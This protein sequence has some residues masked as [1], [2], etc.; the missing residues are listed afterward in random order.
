[1]TK[2]SL[3]ERA[4][5]CRRLLRLKVGCTCG[6]GRWGSKNPNQNKALVMRSPGIIRAGGCAS[7]ET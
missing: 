5:D 1:M 2:Y 3:G 4:A 6:G 7:C